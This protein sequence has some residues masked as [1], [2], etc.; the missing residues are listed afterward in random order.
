M[1]IK[2]KTS[3][4][5]SFLATCIIIIGLSTGVTSCKSND[6]G[7]TIYVVKPKTRKKLYDSKK[8]KRKKRTK[9]VKMIN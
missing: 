6:S 2:L 9:R 5:S 8:H 7:S 3:L 4:F 1:G